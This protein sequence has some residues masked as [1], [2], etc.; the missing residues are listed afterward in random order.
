MTY[1]LEIAEDLNKQFAKLAKRDKVLFAA[2]RKK[3]QE[4]RETPNHYKPLR[5]PMQNKRRVHIGGSFVLIF[6]VDEER[7]TVRLLEFEH[8]D[9]A[10]K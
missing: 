9:R 2:L 4:V 10:Y 8:H 5:A 7:Q 6:S 1:F 3:V